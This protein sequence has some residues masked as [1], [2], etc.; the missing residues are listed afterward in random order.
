MV[1]DDSPADYTIFCD[2]TDSTFSDVRRHAE[3]AAAPDRCFVFDTRDRPLPIVPGIYTSASSRWLAR[4]HV[5]GGVYTKV[6]DHHAIQSTD[7]SESEYLCGFVGSFDTHPIRPRLRILGDCKDVLIRDASSSGQPRSN[8]DLGR[9]WYGAEEYARLL[10]VCRFILCPRGVAPSSYRI[11][12]AMKAARVPVIISDHWVPPLGPKWP[13]FSIRVREC[14]VARIPEILQGINCES[15][16]MGMKARE[17]W[18]L[19]FSER[20]L[21]EFVARSA[22]HLALCRRNSPNRFLTSVRASRLMLFHPF[23]LRDKLRNSLGR[24]G[25]QQD[26]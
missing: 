26:T 3:Y 10:T 13:E 5:A 11:F 7:P 21:I 9:S 1:T 4:D 17:A 25:R 14:E 16:A 12:E 19:H 6:L 22:A 18:D 24:R 8:R 15:M 20:K 2:S 23:H